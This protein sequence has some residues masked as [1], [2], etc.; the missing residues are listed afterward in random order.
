[1]ETFLRRNFKVKGNIACVYK[2][3]DTVHIK[4]V[5]N[6]EVQLWH[7][8]PMIKVFLGSGFTDSS[9]DFIVEFEADSPADYIV[10]GKI[11]DVFLEAYYNGEQLKE[12]DS[13]LLEGLVAYWKL[14]ET[15]GTTAADS[16]GN[17]HDG[18]LTGA[19]LPDWTTGIINNG[20]EFYGTLDGSVLSYMEVP[21]NPDFEFGT[22]DFTYAFWTINNNTSNYSTLLYTGGSPDG[23][24]VEYK[25][26]ST[27][28]VFVN[29]SSVY[30][31]AFIMDSG[32]W[33]L[34]VIR[35]INNK[36]DIVINGISL[37]EEEF[38]GSVSCPSNLLFG[39]NNVT[40]HNLDGKIDEIGIWKGH[41]L[42]D[43]E[44]ALLY[45]N[46]TGRQYPF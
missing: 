6:I 38:S 36:I 25:L 35:R 43:E 39:S 7:Q 27:F 12:A 14:D 15:S 10:D 46:G 24:L 30:Q 32:T 26:P 28:R 33:Y 42:T 40:N 4:Q 18:T 41:G 16:T 2:P 11:G 31:K 17:G 23:L 20:L 8:K 22:G 9:G 3:V 37:G 21:T 29:S 5:E 45:N 13:N 1:M 19:T 44:V 34:F